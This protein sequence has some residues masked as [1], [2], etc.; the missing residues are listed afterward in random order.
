MK[1]ILFCAGLLASLTVSAQTKDGGITKQMLQQIEKQNVPTASDRALRNA[2]AANAIDALA[3]NQKNA[4]ALD[5]YFNIETKKQ[6]IT[7]QK[8]SGR[9]WMFSGMNVLRA[10][11]AK[12]T[13]SL[14]VTFSQD[15]LFFY[16][17]LEKANLMLQGV[18][19]TGKKPIDD[20]RVQFFF[21]HPLNDGG[22]F[23]GVADLTEKYGLVPTEVQPETYSAE[24]TSR[25]SRIISSKLREQGLELRKMVNEGKKAKDIQQRKTE[26]LSEIY[27]MLVITLGE[28]V[29]EFTYAFRDKNG[30]ALTPVKTYTPQS[31]YQEVVG[32]KLNGT[33][34][35]VMND[36]R[37]EY[38]K[39]YEVE[40]DRHTYDGHNWKYLNLPMEDIEQ[41]AIASLKD[42][43]KLY[44]SYDVGKQLDRKRGYADTENYDYESLF[45]TTFGMNKAERI[46][47][48]DS[49]STHAMTLTAVDLDADGKP[50]KWKVE[51]S[52]GSDSGHQGCIIMTARWFREYMFR[53]VVDKKY[54][55]EKL[56]K[57]YDQK[58]I[59]V[60]PEDPLFQ[61]DE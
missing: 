16:D 19:D 39:T 21:H 14:K 48:F 55:S 23:C 25:M 29:K 60:M 41:L 18:I 58:P 2:L 7:N 10:N 46:S 54:V 8:S 57:D 3:K 53:L 52:W 45:G 50:L 43:R 15:Y 47:T 36:P 32:E 22:T 61:M 4:G 49:G 5:T 34:I 42:G 24:S 51:N 56:L 38:Y 27:H 35:M 37:R 26:M 44:S 31:F 1:K 28:P 33:F 12:R 20:Q 30:K 13:D 40:Y 6:S 17:Q 11:F 9:C 59:M